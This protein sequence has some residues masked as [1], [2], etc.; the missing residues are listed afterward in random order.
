M[1]VKVRKGQQLDNQ[2]V[3][4]D[5]TNH[6]MLTMLM[7]MLMLTML[8]LMLMQRVMHKVQQTLMKLMM[9]NSRQLMLSHL[10]KVSV[11]MAVVVVS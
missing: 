6:R 4:C 10:S 7:L 3:T 11:L 2:T 8:M 1:R 5:V 9:L